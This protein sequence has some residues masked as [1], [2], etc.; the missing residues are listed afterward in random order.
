VLYG[1]LLRNIFIGI[2]GQSM[3]AKTL[4]TALEAVEKMHGTG[5]SLRRFVP[6]RANDERL[7]EW[8]GR[9]ERASASPGALRSLVKMNMEMNVRHVLPMI[10][11]PTL[12]VQRTGDRVVLAE[13]VREDARL[14]PNVKYVELPGDD[15]IPI[16]ANADSV[17]D[18]IEEFLTGS[19]PA[20]EPD[21]VL[22][23][24][25]FTDI[26]GSTERAAE[27][28][29]SRWTEL[30]ERYYGAARRELERFRGREIKTTGDGLLAT[31]DG[32]ARA[33][34]CAQSIRDAAKSLGLETRSGL[35]T[36]EC[37]LLGDDVGGIAVHIGARV[38]AEATP[39]E[40]LVSSTVKDLVAG[41]GLTFEERG[42]KRL[43]GVPDEWRL[44]AALS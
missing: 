41:S 29:D 11:V 21:R 17:F 14:I 9:Y 42:A 40:V 32:P 18:E 24:V 35:H 6:S 31:F 28:G 12:V 34:R 38:N 23:T 27:L 25:L 39:G 43:K 37:E 5:V 4:S 8:W 33:I 30:L 19:R 15:H 1:P 10:R 3:D 44:F 26:V 7:K 2:D 36:G 13:H 16:D 22:A 20:H